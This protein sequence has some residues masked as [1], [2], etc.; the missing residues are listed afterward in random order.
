VNGVADTDGL[1]DVYEQ[2]AMCKLFHKN[3]CAFVTDTFTSTT[4]SASQRLK[5]QNAKISFTTDRM[6]IQMEDILTE[7]MVGT[8]Q[9]DK[10]DDGKG[11]ACD[12]K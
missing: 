11:D 5:A 10:D 2:L 12:S 8:F 3:A 4:I 7:Q 1:F 6:K 9:Y